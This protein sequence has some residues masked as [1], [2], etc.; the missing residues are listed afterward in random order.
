MS[1]TD[2]VDTNKRHYA[3]KTIDWI[4]KIVRD[5]SLNT[6]ITSTTN[7][8][9]LSDSY[10]YVRNSVGSSRKHYGFAITNSS[11]FE[12]FNEAVNVHTSSLTRVMLL[13]DSFNRLIPA[14]QFT[15][16]RFIRLVNDPIKDFSY[17]ATGATQNKKHNDF[18]RWLY[19]YKSGAN[20]KY[21]YVAYDSTQTNAIKQFSYTS[22]ASLTVKTVS[23]DLTCAVLI[24]TK[25]ST[26]SSNVVKFNVAGTT[27]TLVKNL[28]GL[29]PVIVA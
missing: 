28:V 19:S 2:S 9:A 3:A 8:I 15:S 21:E 20:Y 18:H 7:S 22:T 10:L 17:D 13:S 12:I 26:K 1:G 29:T 5:I 25:S 11:L 6:G 23:E 27:A 14:Y 16:D 4:N 24:D